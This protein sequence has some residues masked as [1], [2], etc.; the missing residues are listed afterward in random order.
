MIA[1]AASWLTENGRF[2]ANLDM[3]NIKLRDRQSAGRIVA[4]ELRNNGLTYSSRTRLIQRNGKQQVKFP[5]KYL[6]ADD[7]AGPNYTRQPAV[8]SYYEQVGGDSQTKA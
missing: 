5:F 7:N 8:D 4:A 6:G 2:V 3:N 1:R